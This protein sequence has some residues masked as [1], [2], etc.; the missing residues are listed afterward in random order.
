MSELTSEVE[1]RLTEAGEKVRK[2][3]DEAMHT[4]DGFV[5]ENPWLA[6]GL[7]FTAGTLL[8]VLKRRG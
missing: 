8:S 4:V 3:S 1:E 5:R 7:A 2:H 6:L